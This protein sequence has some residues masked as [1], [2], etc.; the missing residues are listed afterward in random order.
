M[1]QFTGLGYLAHYQLG[2]RVYCE[3]QLGETGCE[4]GNPK[5]PQWILRKSRGN[6]TQQPGFQVGFSSIRVG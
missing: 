6:V 4:T 3:A 5:Y 2:R 1:R